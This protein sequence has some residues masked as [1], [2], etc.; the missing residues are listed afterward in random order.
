MESCPEQFLKKVRASYTLVPVNH[1][2]KC[3]IDEGW[4]RE[5][6]FSNQYWSVF[7]LFLLCCFSFGQVNQ[8]TKI[9]NSRAQIFFF[10]KFFPSWVPHQGFWF[11][12]LIWFSFPKWTRL[13]KVQAGPKPVLRNFSR[14]HFRKLSQFRKV[15]QNI[16]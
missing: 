16:K 14:V 15:S 4:R 5:A 11:G 9:H 13:R 3:I 2:A 10:V 7:H 8:P 6:F 1:I 12:F